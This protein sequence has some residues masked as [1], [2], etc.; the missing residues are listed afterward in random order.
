MNVGNIIEIEITWEFKNVIFDRYFLNLI[1]SVINGANFTKFGTH[2]V[3]GHSEGTLSQI[4][5]LGLCFYFIKSRK[6]SCKK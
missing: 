6:F 2:V 4:F 3:E 1:I 5:D